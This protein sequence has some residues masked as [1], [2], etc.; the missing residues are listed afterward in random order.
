MQQSDCL[1]KADFARS[2]N[3]DSF[4][5]LAKKHKKHSSDYGYNTLQINSPCGLVLRQVRVSKS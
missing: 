4:D 2:F 5:H 1:A 3:Q